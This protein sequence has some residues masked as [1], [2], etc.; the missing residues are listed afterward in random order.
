M[1]IKRV[2][3]DIDEKRPLDAALFMCL[4]EKCQHQEFVI[5]P[6]RV[7]ALAGEK[8]PKCKGQFYQH[9][10]VRDDC[11]EVFVQWPPPKKRKR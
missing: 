8:C 5:I 4:K 9:V 6:K 10:I 3:V 11:S 7:N 1:A 2:V